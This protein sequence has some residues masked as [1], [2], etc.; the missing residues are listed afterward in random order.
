M[1]TDDGHSDKNCTEP[2]SSCCKR[3]IGLTENIA[4]HTASQE[5]FD[6]V[7]KIRDV[8]QVEFR[9]EQINDACT[10]CET[11]YDLLKSF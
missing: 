8:L 1:T 6:N 2:Q 10:D 5:R 4:D 3:G 9:N 7:Y 11:Q